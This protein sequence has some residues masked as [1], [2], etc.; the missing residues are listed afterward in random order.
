MVLCLNIAIV[1]GIP[2]VYYSGIEGDFN[3]MVMDL[4][5]PTLEDLLEFT[6]RKYSLKSTLMIGSQ[7]VLYYLLDFRSRELNIC[8]QRTFCIEMLNQKIF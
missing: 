3:V 2:S 7:M 1:E 5:G 4:L 6:G 8:I